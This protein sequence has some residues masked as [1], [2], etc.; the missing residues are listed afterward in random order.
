ML[1]EGDGIDWNWI[2]IAV[3]NRFYKICMDVTLRLA[4]VF[5]ANKEVVSEDSLEQV[6]PTTMHRMP[7]ASTGIVA[8]GSCLC[9]LE[10]GQHLP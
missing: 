2:L 3:I 10:K 9:F 5:P 7:L 6:S 4:S 8:C 1:S